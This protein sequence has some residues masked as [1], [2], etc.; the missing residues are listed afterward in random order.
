MCTVNNKL[1]VMQKLSSN[2]TADQTIVLCKSWYFNNLA[3]LQQPN[4]MANKTP[5]FNIFY[6]RNPVPQ[7]DPQTDYFSFVSS[8]DLL[9]LARA[10]LQTLSRTC[11][12]IPAG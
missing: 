6:N 12:A 3:L 1:A 11:S 2:S 5:P 7:M 9:V 4:W 10:S 8:Q